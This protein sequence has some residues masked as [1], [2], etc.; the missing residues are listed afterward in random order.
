MKPTHPLDRR[1]DTLSRDEFSYQEQPGLGGNSPLDIYKTVR[2]LIAEG[3]EASVAVEAAI[4]RAKH[5]RGTWMEGCEKHYDPLDELE[6]DIQKHMPQPLKRVPFE[7]FR[8]TRHNKVAHM[9]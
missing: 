8:K 9:G 4:N 1:I 7:I 5:A 3:N 2:K 6:H